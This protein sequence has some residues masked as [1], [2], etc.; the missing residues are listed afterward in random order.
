[1]KPAFRLFALALSAASSLTAGTITVLEDLRSVS[2]SGSAWGLA[3]NQGSTYHSTVPNGNSVAGSA[4]WI[5]QTPIRGMNT[6]PELQVS[7]AATMTSVVSAMSLS[8]YG[9]LNAQ[10]WSNPGF[11]YASLSATAGAIFDITFQLDTPMSYS[12]EMLNSAF[13]GGGGNPSFFFETPMISL[14]SLE[15]GPVVAS[16]GV[17]QGFGQFGL[18]TNGMLGAGIY[19]LIFNPFTQV[20]GDPYGESGFVNYSMALN[21]AE[22]VMASHIQA[23]VGGVSVPDG[24]STLVLLLISG[25]A[26][27]L[28]VLFAA[29]R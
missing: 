3:E 18:S 24:G 21:F 26:M 16:T 14:I 22:P 9:Q 25:G 23:S 15:N 19:R 20:Q 8:A 29:R 27:A 2:V 6:Q 28:S 5:V 13:H 1:M 17:S 11:P 4:Q 12:L 7:S 10:S